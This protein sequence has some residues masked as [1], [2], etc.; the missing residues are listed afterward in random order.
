MEHR[1]RILELEASF[2]F[3]LIQVIGWWYTILEH[4]IE[5]VRLFFSPKSAFI[6]DLS[7]TKHYEEHVRGITSIPKMPTTSEF[8]FPN[9]LQTEKKNM[10]VQ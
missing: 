3:Y 1:F 5:Y 9:Y 8:G 6:E 7:C 4:N 2:L 10:V